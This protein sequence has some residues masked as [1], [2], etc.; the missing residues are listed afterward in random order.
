MASKDGGP[1]FP[2]TLLYED[3]EGVMN[4]VSYSFMAGMSLRDYFAAAAIS[5]QGSHNGTV[6]QDYNQAAQ[7]AYELA[8]AMLRERERKPTNET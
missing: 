2:R 7:W 3:Q 8:D 1:A 5:N 4:A 6:P